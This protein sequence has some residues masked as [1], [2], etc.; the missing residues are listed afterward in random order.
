MTMTGQALADHQASMMRQARDAGQLRAPS[1]LL[2]MLS[3]W[4][5]AA[6]ADQPRE[7]ATWARLAKITEEHG[8]AVAAYIGATGQ[9]P[10]KG[11]T[12]DIDD[13]C[14]E[15]LDVAVSALLA[16]EHLAE[17]PGG[18]WSA[19]AAHIDVLAARAFLDREE[20]E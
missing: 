4:I 3:A 16:Y 5:G 10:R 17:L 15:L 7:A 18:T 1:T 13:V 12:H 11:I 9:N 8:E 6:N 20:T 2:P 19:L 14:R